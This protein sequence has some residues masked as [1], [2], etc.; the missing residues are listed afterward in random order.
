M[1]SLGPF[2][3]FVY[4]V[5]LIYTLT[6]AFPSQWFG[7]T[8]SQPLTMLTPGT[9]GLRLVLLVFGRDKAKQIWRRPSHCGEVP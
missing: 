2:H 3:Q 1:V 4:R 6:R 9:L 5:G 8:T 7:S